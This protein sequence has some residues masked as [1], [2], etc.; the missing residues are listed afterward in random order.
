VIPTL[1]ATDLEE[2]ATVTTTVVPEGNEETATKG[3]ETDLEAKTVE[4]DGEDVM[5]ASVADVIGRVSKKKTP[6]PSTSRARLHR[7]SP[8]SLT[9]RNASVA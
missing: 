3:A 4:A 5:E 8:A 7:I 1:D 9:S 2:T 6:R